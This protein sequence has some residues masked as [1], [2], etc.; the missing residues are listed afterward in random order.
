MSDHTQLNLH[1]NT[2]A[3]MDARNKQ[4]SAL[5]AILALCF[6]QNV[7]HAQAY[8]NK[9]NKYYNLIKASMDF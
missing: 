7:E 8:L 5:Y 2:V 1:N 3:F 4:N 6:L 9:H